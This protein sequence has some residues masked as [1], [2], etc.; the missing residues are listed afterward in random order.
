MRKIIPILLAIILLA[1]NLADSAQC[2]T[3]SPSSLNSGTLSKIERKVFGRTFIGDDRVNR[4]TR[5]EREVFG[6]IQKGKG[7]VRLARLKTATQNYT[8]KYATQYNLANKRFY[9]GYNY[10]YNYYNNP[11]NMYT[12]YRPYKRTGLKQ[13]FRALTGT[14]LTGF[15][16]P[17]S[18]FDVNTQSGYNS[19]YGNP[20]NNSYST[21]NQYYTNSS[22]PN[23]YRDM[24]SN[25]ASGSEMYYDDGRYRKNLNSTG[26][27]CGATI[28]Y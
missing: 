11:Y 12:P 13:F 7:P 6:A 26:G 27:G 17:P 22:N 21:A 25:G 19:P 5:L 2:E 15:S 1:G 9:P 16:P 23:N 28:I 8:N 14:S 20:Y 10:N 24:F 3:I 4:L 18:S